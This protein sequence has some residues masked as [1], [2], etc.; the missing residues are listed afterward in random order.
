MRIFTASLATET[1]TFSP[2]PTDRASFETAFYAG[3][4]QHPETPTLCSAP[5]VVLR[6][7]REARRLHADRRHGGLGGAGR[8]AATQGLRGSAR[9]DPRPIARRAAGRWRDSRSARRDGRARLR[10]LRGRF[11]GAGARDRRPEGRRSPR[12]STRTAISPGSAS[13]TPTSS[14]RSSNFRTPIFSSARSMWST[15]RC[16]RCAA[17]SG[18]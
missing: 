10:R 13:R 14:R 15:S 17:K 5:M 1:N 2:I 4:G 18:P 12:N 7:R 6:R 9:R 3:P 11:A 8:V 16:A